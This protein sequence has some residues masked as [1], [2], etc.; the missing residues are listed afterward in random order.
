M[1]RRFSLRAVTTLIL[2]LAPRQSPALSS[3]WA[4]CTLLSSGHAPI[5]LFA[6]YQFLVSISETRQIFL[7]L[8]TTSVYTTTQCQEQDTNMPT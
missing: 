5:K 7:Q 1:K 6:R 8:A 2:F 3:I 4:I